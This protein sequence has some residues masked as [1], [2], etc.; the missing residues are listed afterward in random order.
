MNTKHMALAAALAASLMLGACSRNDA[1]APPPVA[2]DPTEVPTS[3]MAT[4][5]T[6]VDW[7]GAQAASE[8][9]DPLG[10]VSIMPPV[11]DNDEPATIR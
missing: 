9:L 4:T 7:T 8:S 3:A 10:M 5:Q 11:S 2:Q 6:L 1:D